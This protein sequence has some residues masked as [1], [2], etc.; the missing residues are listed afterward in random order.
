MLTLGENPIVPRGILP[1]PARVYHALIEL[2]Q[3]NNL[4]PN[5]LYSLGLNLGGYIE[6]IALA[7]PLA[8]A[9]GLIPRL[10]AS[11]QRP[12]DSIRFLVLPAAIGLFIAWFGI[13]SWMKIHFLAFGILIYLLPIA[14]QRI[15]EVNDVY[16]KT[17]YTLG[18]TPW[19]MIRTV[20]FPSV[21]SRLFS[22]IRIL[23]AISWTY[24]VIAESIGGEAGIGALTWQVGLR[25]G[26]IDKVFCLLI[27]I[28]LV[29]IFQDKLFAYFDKKFFPFKY[30]AERPGS[31]RKQ[32][33]SSYKEIIFGFSGRIMV[34]TLLL[35]YFLLTLDEYFGIFGHMNLLSYLFRDTVWVFHL[36]WLLI[37]GTLSA[38]VQKKIMTRLKKSA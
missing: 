15:D 34:L 18:A 13:G 8:F 5:F 32:E 35:G 10:R 37:V 29:G 23:T 38:G 33:T 20:Y 24:I 4:I 30:Q 12:V 11:F 19:Q 36:F 31:G 17:V 26:R 21:I 27:I 14:I 22:D 28:M 1:S 16:L 9:L 3:E 25:R 6:A 2:L 7:I